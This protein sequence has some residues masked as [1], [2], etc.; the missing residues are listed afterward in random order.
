MTAAEAAVRAARL[1][2]ARAKRALS[3]GG[4]ALFWWRRLNRAAEI[5]E[6]AAAILRGAMPAIPRAELVC[7]HGRR[8][9]DCRECAIFEDGAA[10]AIYK[11]A[12]KR[13]REGV[14]MGGR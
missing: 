4:P 5:F 11:Q 10:E 12:C 6:Q 3:A 14:L 1:E 9:I 8:L 13:W 2:A 7:D